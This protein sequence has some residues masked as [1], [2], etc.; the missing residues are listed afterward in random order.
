I[1]SSDIYNSFL[2]AIKLKNSIFCRGYYKV[3]EN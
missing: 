2:I 1:S 3:K